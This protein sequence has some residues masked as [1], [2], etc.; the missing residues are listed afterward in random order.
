MSSLGETLRNRFLDAQNRIEWADLAGA[1]TGAV[2]LQWF[3]GGA[4][5][6]LGIGRGIARVFG[7]I[8]SSISDGMSLLSTTLVNQ[9]DSAF[10][11]V[12]FGVFSLPV[13][14]VLILVS[15]AI[16]VIGFQQVVFDE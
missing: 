10:G 9:A 3:R 16:V 12:D 15:V 1:V 7:G 2:T 14:L 5:I 8:S 4:G 13:S 6:P 11:P